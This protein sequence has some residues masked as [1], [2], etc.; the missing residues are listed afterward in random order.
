MITWRDQSI[1]ALIH[2][3][4]ENMNAHHLDL[5]EVPVA[6]ESDEVALKKV[7]EV[8]LRQGIYITALLQVVDSA[9]LL[10]SSDPYLR[11][12]GQLKVRQQQITSKQQ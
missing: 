7:Y 1:Y 6:G 4:I 2:N 5:G 8:L 9:V 3:Y 11:K 10:T 12:L